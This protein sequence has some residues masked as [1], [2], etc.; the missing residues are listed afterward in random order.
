MF[1][2]F[3]NF[4]FSSFSFKEIS[5]SYN[6]PWNFRC[7]S[8]GLFCKFANMQWLDYTWIFIHHILSCVL[9]CFTFIL[10]KET[11]DR[12]TYEHLTKIVIKA[13]IFLMESF[14]RAPSIWKF[15]FGHMRTVKAQINLHIHAVWSRPSLLLTELLDTTEYKNGEQMPK[16]YFVHA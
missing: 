11:C 14:I 12:W 6:K 9:F 8:W 2:F 10:L 1:F 7:F 4:L 5:I 16:C 15:V 3:H 13:P